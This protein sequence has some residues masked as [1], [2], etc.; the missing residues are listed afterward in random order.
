ML[1]TDFYDTK[2]AELRLPK[3]A[4]LEIISALGVMSD[5]CGSA[6]LKNKNGD[7]ICAECL[8]CCDLVKI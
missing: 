3:K 7:G 1:L 8:E 6:V 4:E 5:C 2:K